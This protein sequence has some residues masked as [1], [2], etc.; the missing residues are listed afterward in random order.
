MICRVSQSLAEWLEEHPR[1]PTQSIRGRE[2][3]VQIDD[4]ESTAS[5]I[6][7][8]TGM[9]V[10]QPCE[11]REL[12]RQRAQ[13]VAAAHAPSLY[14]CYSPDG[15]FRLEVVS[16]TQMTESGPLTYAQQDFTLRVFDQAGCLRLQ[17][18]SCKAWNDGDS[19]QESGLRSWR[20]STNGRELE[21]LFFDGTTQNL[22]IPEVEASPGEEEFWKAR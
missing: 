22:T 11:L 12:V 3:R 21:L 4:F 20:F 18:L 7:S 5:W 6:L 17:H 2:F 9:E 19:P 15:R 16:D 13:A 10:L 8:L 1:H 14:R